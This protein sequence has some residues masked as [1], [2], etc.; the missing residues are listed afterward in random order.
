MSKPGGADAS[1]LNQKNI[2]STFS[3]N[4]GNNNGNNNFN[5]IL[6]TTSEAIAQAPTVAEVSQ[7]AATDANNLDSTTTMTDTSILKKKRTNAKGR[8]TT[9][10][11]SST[12]LK[13]TNL[14]LGTLSLLGR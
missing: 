13:D 2:T 7:S 1:S 10:L 8:S 6:S 3:N 11:T 4:N 5:K 14:K 9:I 12:G